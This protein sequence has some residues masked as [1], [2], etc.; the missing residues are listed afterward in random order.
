MYKFWLKKSDLRVSKFCTKVMS[1]SEPSKQ[2]VTPW[3]VEGKVDYLRLVEQFGTEVIDKNLIDRF[4]KVTGKVVHPWI[5]RGIFFSHRGLNKFLDAVEN[6]TPIFLYTGRGPSTSAMHLGHLVPFIFTKWLQ[7]TFD[8]PLVIQ[9]SD[10]EKSA[11]K[12]QNFNEIYKL[13]F[14]N[15]K[16]IIACGFDA[17]KTFIFS[18]RDYRLKCRQFEL[19]ASEMRYLTNLK[20]IKRIF[21]LTDDSTVAMYD[22]PFY[23]TAAAYY[24]AYPHIFK[25]RPA[26]CL[27]PHAI[28]QD[29]YFRLA[30]DLSSKMNLFKP[31]NIMSTFVPSLSGD[32]GK[33]SSSTNKEHTVF[34]NDSEKVIKEKVMKHSFSGGGGDGSLS[35]HKKFGGNPDKDIAFQYLR[36]FEMDD[37][38]LEDIRIA[39]MKGEMS[40]GELKMILLEKL[41]PL[42]VN[43]KEQ[44]SKVDQSTVDDF[45]ND[46]PLT[47]GG[48]HRNN[49]HCSGSNGGYKIILTEEEGKLYNLFAQLNIKYHTTYHSDIKLITQDKEKENDLKMSLQG[50]LC[51]TVLLKGQGS[52]YYLCLV[53]FDTLVSP[54]DLKKKLK[55]SR[56]NFAEKDTVKYLFKGNKNESI[57]IDGNY[58]S[59]FALSPLSLINFRSDNINTINLHLLIEDSLQEFEYLNF[60]PLR[61]DASTTISQKDLHKFLAIFNFIP[62]PRFIGF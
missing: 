12:Q 57:N 6:G 18:N 61:S 59:Q 54:K 42:I 49:I 52:D 1:L 2:I 31:S 30:R 4:E 27:V 51:K 36:Y 5:R 25:D 50:V 53:K 38:K 48:S 24:L 7:E 39:F 13:G 11:F 23:Q 20:E 21:G 14:E 32:S 34:L 41:L 26:M 10:E 45:Y 8:C 29:P 22:W 35:D 40:C 28:D 37:Q 46:K 43:L 44:R 3:S 58:V 17:K 16:D 55:S 62:A 33:M 15:S 56:L 47:W 19:L 60:H 9:I